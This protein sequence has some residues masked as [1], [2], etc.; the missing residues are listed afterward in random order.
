MTQQPQEDFDGS[1]EDAQAW[2]R[3]VQEQLQANDDTQGPRAALEA[4]LRETEVRG[5]VRGPHGPGASVSHLSGGSRSRA[6]LGFS[7]LG[8]LE[9]VQVPIQEVKVGP[10]CGISDT[11]PVTSLFPVLGPHFHLPSGSPVLAGAPC[12]QVGPLPHLGW[13]RWAFRGL[14][15]GCAH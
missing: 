11:S 6:L 5:D 4:R 9:E 12:G 15:G 14:G 2:M 8:I 7:L 10:R 13:P 3:A 1:V